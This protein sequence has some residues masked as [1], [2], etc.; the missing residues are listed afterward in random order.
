VE[1]KILRKIE[2]IV[3]ANILRKIEAMWRLKL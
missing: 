1:A 3:E 2:A